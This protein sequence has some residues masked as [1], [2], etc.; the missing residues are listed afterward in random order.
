MPFI[1]RRLNGK[2]R[3]HKV[4]GENISVSNARNGLPAGDDH[5]PAEQVCAQLP[6]RRPGTH[7]AKVGVTDQ[8]PTDPDTLRKIL[9]GLNRI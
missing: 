8:P 1:R 5:A 7:G 9:D 3:M 6:K 4:N 2:R